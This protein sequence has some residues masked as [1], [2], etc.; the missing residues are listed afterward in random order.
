MVDF[1]DTASLNSMVMK[2]LR[3]DSANNDNA[4]NTTTSHSEVQAADAGGTDIRNPGVHTSRIE[5]TTSTP[6]DSDQSQSGMLQG[7]LLTADLRSRNSDKSA[8]TNANQGVDSVQNN[9]QTES[10]Q[11]N[12]RARTGTILVPG[13]QS[14]G[15]DI[16]PGSRHI[17]SISAP[18]V[19]DLQSMGRRA[20]HNLT[21]PNLVSSTD[22][23][24]ERQDR[25]MEM[26]IVQEILNDFEGE[27]TIGD[28]DKDQVLIPVR[29]RLQKR[30]SDEVTD[31]VLAEISM[32][33]ARR[34]LE[35]D[36]QQLQ[37]QQ[38]EPDRQ[39]PS[40]SSGDSSGGSSTCLNHW[41]LDSSKGI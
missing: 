23:G 1:E 24:A 4:P 29:R 26:Q 10:K 5:L 11:S 33:L 37:A 6:F 2:A 13:G 27:E 8:S 31:R 18:G 34:R 19:P 15:P 38:E 35:E 41:N 22:V 9:L 12:E 7:A 21:G 30:Y 40:Y 14:Q 36:C 32:E 25:L 3:E 20:P 28:R 16:A 17:G 39:G